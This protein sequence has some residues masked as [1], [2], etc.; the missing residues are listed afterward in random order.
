M[1][2]ALLA[3]GLAGCASSASSS[4]SSPTPPDDASTPSAEPTAAVAGDPVAVG[5]AFVEA[6]ARGDTATAEAMED[7][8]LRAAAPAAMLDQLWDQLVAQY[9][10]FEGLADTETKEQPPYTVATVHAS[11]ANADVPL[12]GEYSEPGHVAAEVVADLAAWILEP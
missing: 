5:R 7:D 2:V 6:L 12:L 3:L 9:G 10:A 8:T 1:L 4:P 11:F